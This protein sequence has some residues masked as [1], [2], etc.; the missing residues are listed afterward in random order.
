MAWHPMV[1]AAA[2]SYFSA[3]NDSWLGGGV[4]CGV[5]AWRNAS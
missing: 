1:V 5:M 4:V 2:E 3:I